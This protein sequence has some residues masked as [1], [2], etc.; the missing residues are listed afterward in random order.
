VSRRVF[1]PIVAVLVLA[2]AALTMSVWSSAPA[3]SARGPRLRPTRVL[4]DTFAQVLCRPPADRETVDWDSRPFDRTTLAQALASTDEAQRVMEIRA[5]HVDLLR[6]EAGPGDCGRIRQWIDRGASAD[7]ARRE[8]ARLPEARRVD[9]VRR[10]F[11][12]TF[13]RDP[14]EWDDPALRRWVDSP[15]TVAEIRSRLVAQRPLVGVHYFAWYQLASAGW[16]NDLTTVPPDSPKPVVGRYES[17]DTDVI[18]THI[19]QMEEAG[20]DFAIVHVIAGFPRT[21]MTAR[22]FVDRLS[23]HRLKAAILV[24]GL[25]ESDAATKAMWVRKAS[26]EFAGDSHYLRID[27][28]PLVMLFSAPLDFDVPGV[29]LRNV[30]WTDR[31]DPGRNTFNGNHRLEP[32]DWPF[33]APTPQPL[34]NGV[35]PVVPG[36][37]DA[38]LGRARTMVHP[39]GNGQMYREQWQRALA[40]HPELILVYSWNEYFEQTAIEPT[41]AWGSQYLQISACFIAH[42]HRGT[43]GRC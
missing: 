34:V 1:L 5:L 19:R 39:R 25:Y 31:Y 37:T 21:W 26:D 11:V 14:R 30:Y 12:D 9:Q 3:R 7:D 2:I 28:Q 18:A 8:L 23:G 6:R 40:L 36:Y 27:G 20:F 35:V 13:G 17:S 15:Y 29:A 24:D 22:T 38:S 41:E 4:A 33:W 10:V 16:R 32:R 42:A 43:A